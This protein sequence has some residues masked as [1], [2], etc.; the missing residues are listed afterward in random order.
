[1]TSTP[2][3]YRELEKSIHTDLKDRMS[4]G[5]YLHLNEVLNAQ[6]PLSDQHCSSSFTRRASSG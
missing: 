6:H 3:N 4:Y 5:D 2:K 1:M